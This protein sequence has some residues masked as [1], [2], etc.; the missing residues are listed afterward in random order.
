MHHQE[1]LVPI[2]LAK[3]QP[4]EGCVTIVD[5]WKYDGTDRVRRRFFKYPDLNLDF[6]V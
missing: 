6:V 1:I 2:V 3:I 4:I 5:V